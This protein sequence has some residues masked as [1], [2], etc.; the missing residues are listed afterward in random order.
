MNRTCHSMIVAAASGWY[1]F[2]VWSGG[3]RSV[4]ADGVLWCGVVLPKMVGRKP[5][6]VQGVVTVSAVRAGFEPRPLIEP[7]GRLRAVQAMHIAA[8]H[9][10]RTTLFWSL[11]VG[12]RWPRLKPGADREN[13][14]HTLGAP[15]FS[16]YHF[17]RDYA[18]PG[19]PHRRVLRMRRISA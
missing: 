8:P 17:G 14:Y 1:P 10:L 18:A 7:A 4:A 5:R 13:G 11:P 2:S 6:R 19:A 3:R 12:A 9:S 15:R 16:P